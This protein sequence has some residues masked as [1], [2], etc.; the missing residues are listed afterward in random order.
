MGKKEVR[1]TK[2]EVGMGILE[3]ITKGLSNSTKRYLH[4]NFE[5]ALSYIAAYHITG[6]TNVIRL[7][8][9]KAVC[10]HE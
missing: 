1:L 6:D 3:N 2:E 10:D 5:V 9:Q 8:I 7:L 4:N